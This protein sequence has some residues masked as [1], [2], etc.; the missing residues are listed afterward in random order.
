MTRLMGILLVSPTMPLTG[1]PGRDRAA[2]SA[3]DPGGDRRQRR[4][5][6]DG[7][8]LAGDEVELL[9]TRRHGALERALGQLRPG[10]R[11]AQDD[12]AAQPQAQQLARRH[13]AA[14]A[15]LG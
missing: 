14:L 15:A 7:G 3:R 10:A 12:P 8:C 2:F 5:A 4:L 6:L 13:R 11:L 1:G 9:G